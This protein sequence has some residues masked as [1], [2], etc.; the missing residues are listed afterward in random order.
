MVVIKWLPFWSSLGTTPLPY[1]FPHFVTQPESDGSFAEVVSPNRGLGDT[2]F[3]VVLVYGSDQ[4]IGSLYNAFMSM[5]S[6]PCV[7]Q[8]WTSFEG[9]SKLVSN[10]LGIWGTIRYLESTVA[11]FYKMVKLLH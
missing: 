1:A 9:H 6:C 2:S 11:Q 3:I 4:S 7:S 5:P 10:R 8:F